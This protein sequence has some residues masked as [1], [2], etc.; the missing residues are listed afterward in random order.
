[1]V[2]LLFNK[3]RTKYKK[4]EKSLCLLTVRLPTSKGFYLLKFGIHVEEELKFHLEQKK[5]FRLSTII[6]CI[7][8]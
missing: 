5:F 1:M 3:L 2:F 6:A 4:T 7:T 8:K